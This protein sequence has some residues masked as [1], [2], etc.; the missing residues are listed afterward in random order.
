MWVKHVS[1]S[2]AIME[3][4]LKD[5]GLELKPSK[6]RLT[7][8]LSVYEAQKPGFDFLGFNIRQFPKGKHHTGKSAAYKS[9]WRCFPIRRELGLLEYK[10]V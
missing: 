3:E 6:T 10:N 2:Y 4:W 7:H 1:R 9:C 5:Y 8:T